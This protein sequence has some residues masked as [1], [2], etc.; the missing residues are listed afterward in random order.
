MIKKFK[1]ITLMLTVMVLVFTVIIRVPV[2][3][4]DYVHIE[5][6]GGVIYPDMKAHWNNHLVSKYLNDAWIYSENG[7]DLPLPNDISAT[8][9][10]DNLTAEQFEQLMQ[11]INEKIPAAEIDALRQRFQR[12]LTYQITDS[13]YYRFHERMLAKVANITPE[14]TR[15]EAKFKLDGNTFSNY[16]EYYSVGAW[17]IRGN[18]G[19]DESIVF[20]SVDSFD[21]IG[22]TL[23]TTSKY[24]HTMFFFGMFSEFKLD[25][26][27]VN[28]G[29]ICVTGI[30][31]TRGPDKAGIIKA[32]T[33]SGVEIV[34]SKVEDITSE[35]EEEFG[36]FYYSVLKF[37]FDIPVIAGKSRVRFE[38][39]DSDNY[40]TEFNLTINVDSTSPTASTPTSAPTAPGTATPTSSAVYV[41]GVPVDFEA[42]F[43]DGNNY[44]KLRD[45]AK[46]VSG[47]NKQ[48]EIAYDSVTRAISLTSG[49]PYTLVGGELTLGDGSAKTYTTNEMV[50]YKDGQKIEMTSYLIG[51]NN[52]LKL[53]DVMKLFNI[54]VTYDSETRNIGIDTQIGYSE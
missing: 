8:A 36:D 43:I 41:N 47:T 18:M 21:D 44:F 48:F 39:T 9:R 23:A 20:S 10:V 17:D 37:T 54:G 19:V 12:G 33:D 38:E 42:Y 49:K 28:E 4:T 26:N 31:S 2:F 14:D 51:G 3:A 50:L 15:I 32:F 46:A 30:S 35:Y 53:R 40:T 13:E 6:S 25:I 22:K 11:F 34:S 45:L 5:S 52:F 24:P 27:D 16:Y 7:V 1:K 29:M